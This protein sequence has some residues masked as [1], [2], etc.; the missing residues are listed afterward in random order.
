[1][2]RAERHNRFVPHFGKIE[3]DDS[4]IDGIH[5]SWSS[6]IRFTAFPGPLIDW[7]R[8]CFHHVVQSDVGAE[9]TS[10]HLIVNLN[11]RVD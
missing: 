2:S 1:M 9:R 5:Y 3:F 6:K 7:F 10:N 4:I 8:R 11:D